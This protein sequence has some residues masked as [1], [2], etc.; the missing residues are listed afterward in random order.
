MLWFVI[1]D[2]LFYIWFRQLFRSFQRRFRRQR[3]H[4]WGIIVEREP[5]VTAATTFQPPTCTASTWFVVIWFLI[6]IILLHADVASVAK[7]PAAAVRQHICFIRRL[8]RGSW[9]SGSLRVTCFDRV[10]LEEDASFRLIFNQRAVL[11]FW[12]LFFVAEVT[13]FPTTV[14]IR[15][16]FPVM[17]LGNFLFHVSSTPFGLHFNGNL[18]LIIICIHYVRWVTFW[19]LSRHQILFEA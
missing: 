7:D 11:N 1:S 13:F 18:A 5:D 6:I 16:K 19:K 4:I 15:N 12:N 14:L 17:S 2:S 9:I 3:H 10:L 8:F